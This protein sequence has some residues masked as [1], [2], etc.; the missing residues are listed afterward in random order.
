MACFLVPTAAAIVT[1]AVSKKLPE[2]CHAN[3][4]NSMLWGGVVMLAV[5]HVAHGEV[6][7]YPPFLTAS[8][9]EVFPE[10]MRVGAP[11]TLVIFLAWMIMITVAAVMSKKERCA[12]T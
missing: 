6:I 5:E 4:L 8:L 3:W 9:R 7:P 11:M 10:M 12:V 1:T 2:E